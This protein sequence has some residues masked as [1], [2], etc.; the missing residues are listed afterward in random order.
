MVFMLSLIK[1]AKYHKSKLTKF[2]YCI[3]VQKSIVFASSHWKRWR[4]YFEGLVTLTLDKVIWHTVMYH[5][6]TST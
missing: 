6:P 2:R 5:S 1:L 3:M 4:R